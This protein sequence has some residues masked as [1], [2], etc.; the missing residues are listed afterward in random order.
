MQPTATTLTG[1][2]PLLLVLWVALL[3]ANAHAPTGELPRAPRRA[4]VGPHVA[5]AA[6]IDVSR[7]WG[8]WRPD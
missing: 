3:R 4:I 1:L 5:R 6:A 2:V 7:T 8:R